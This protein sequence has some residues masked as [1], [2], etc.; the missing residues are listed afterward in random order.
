MPGRETSWTGALCPHEQV[1]VVEKLRTDPW[2][3]AQLNPAAEIA[4]EAAGAFTAGCRVSAMPSWSRSN[5]T[6]GQRGGQKSREEE[7]ALRKAPTSPSSGSYQ[8]RCRALPAPD[9]RQITARKMTT[10]S[11]LKTR[12]FLFSSTPA[13]AFRSEHHP[14]GQGDGSLDPCDGSRNA[15]CN[16]RVRPLH[17]R[18]LGKGC[19]SSADK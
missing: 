4:P 13:F 9:L 3:D 5:C 1:R 6:R 7:R 11:F 10:S 14:P 8:P 15:E 12:Y 16:P 19:S 2:P 18:L 17:L